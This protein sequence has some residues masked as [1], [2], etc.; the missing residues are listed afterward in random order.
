MS[1]AAQ[2]DLSKKPVSII[3]P[4]YDDLGGLNTTLQSLSSTGIVDH[5]D[6]E[7]IVCNDGG[8]DEVSILV[9]KFG[10][11]EARLENNL[12]SY[13]ARNEGIKVAHG[14]ILAFLDA[15]QRVDGDW[16]N[17]GIKDLQ[18]NDYVGGRIVIETGA[19][20]SKW[21]RYDLLT[22]FPVEEYLSVSHFAPTANLFVQREVFDKVGLFD[23]RFKS[24]GD[25]EFGQRVYNAGFKQAYNPNA[26]TYHP[27]R[28]WSKQLKK[29]KRVGEGVTDMKY[30]VLGKR[31][32]YIFIVGCLVI[33]K[34]PVELIWR[35][36]HNLIFNQQQNTLLDIH[37]IIM[38]MTKKFFFHWYITR[39]A[40]YLF[41]N[42]QMAKSWL[43]FKA[44]EQP[45]K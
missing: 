15:D 38:Q 40:A 27:P 32:I 7:I 3:I 1:S 12:G 28:G 16:L 34:I 35:I 39:R 19:S 36:L 20:P 45:N 14:K 41:F 8:G 13:A 6:T 9:E 33:G 42:K 29:V 25:V 43:N 17:E 23:H 5:P 31:P 24:G 2:K 30:L 26:L 21:E 11:R 44:R 22:A 37:H 10:V 4:V 18:D